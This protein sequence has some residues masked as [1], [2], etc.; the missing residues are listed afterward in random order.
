MRE[1]HH[2]QFLIVDITKGAANSSAE[3]TITE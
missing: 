3:N 1:A 2:E